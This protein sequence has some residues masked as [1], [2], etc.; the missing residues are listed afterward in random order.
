MSLDRQPLACNSNDIN[1]HLNMPEKHWQLQDGP[2]SIDTNDPR[3]LAKLRVME[4]QIQCLLIDDP[5]HN[6]NLAN[7][8]VELATAFGKMNKRCELFPTVLFELIKNQTSRDQQELSRQ[9][10]SLLEQAFTTHGLLHTTDNIPT[11]TIQKLA[12]IAYLKA[13]PPKQPQPFLPA[14]SS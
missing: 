9:F 11:Q 10:E 3:C 6:L 1:K 12:V 5:F 14:S 2:N 4:T 13:Q 8:V 7:E